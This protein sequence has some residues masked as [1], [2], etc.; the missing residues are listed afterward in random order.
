MTLKQ[1]LFTKA[2]ENWIKIRQAQPPLKIFSAGFSDL[3]V[4]RGVL[5]SSLSHLEP[6]EQAFLCGGNVVVRVIVW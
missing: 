3:V 1:Y 4:L 2:K 6:A 5:K